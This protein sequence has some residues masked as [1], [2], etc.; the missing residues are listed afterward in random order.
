MVYVIIDLEDGEKHTWLF[1]QSVA[2]RNK[3]PLKTTMEAIFDQHPDIEKMFDVL[4]RELAKF[5]EISEADLKVTAEV[6]NL[7][8]LDAVYQQQSKGHK[9]RYQKLN[10]KN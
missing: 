6:F 9:A 2:L 5:E 1:K 3:T 8:L 7:K 10:F 4:C